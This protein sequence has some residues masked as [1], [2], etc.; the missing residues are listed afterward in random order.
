[1]STLEELQSRATA[2]LTRTE[3]PASIE[4]KVASTE[5]PSRRFSPFIPSELDRAIALAG[6]LMGIAEAQDVGAALDEAA[7]RSASSRTSG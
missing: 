5:G 4:A 7:R 6:E 1:V 3:S 2:L